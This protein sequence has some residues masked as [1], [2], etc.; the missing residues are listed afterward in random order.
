MVESASRESF[1]MLKIETFSNHTGGNALYKALSHPKTFDKM[2]QLINK[3]CQQSVALYDPLGI[4][5]PV[6]E[7]YKKS[8]EKLNITSIYAQDF[9]HIGKSYSSI[10]GIATQPLTQLHASKAEILL[11]LSFDHEPLLS[12]L[13]PYLPQFIKIYSL[14]DIR[15][16]TLNKQGRY[17]TPLNFATNF[18]FFREEDGFHTRLVTAN[19]WNRYGGKDVYLSCVLFGENGKILAQ[20]DETLRDSDHSIIIDSQE[21]K[22]RFKLEPFTGQLFFH[23]IGAVGHDVVKYA[24]N[25]FNEDGTHLSCTHDANS[26]PADSYAGLPAP[27]NNEEVYFWIQNNH[28]IPIPSTTMGLNIMGQDKISWLDKEIA[29]FATYRLNV[30]DLLPNAKWP[31]Q[32]EIHTGKYVVRPRYEVKCKSTQQQ[33]IAHVNVQRND[34]KPTIS[35]ADLKPLFGKSYILPAP[36]L[37]QATFESLALPTPMSTTQNKLPLKVFIYDATGHQVAEKSLGVLSRDLTTVIDCKQWS[38]PSGYG[39]MELAYDDDHSDVLVDGWLHGLFRYERG[40]HK[41]E[42]S[43]GA[44]IFNTALV[45]QNEPQSY[46]GAPPGLR[47]RLFLALSE[48]PQ[49]STCFLIYP[50]STPWHPTSQTTFILHNRDGQEIAEHSIKIP[51]SGSYLFSFLQSFPEEMRVKAKDGYVIVRDTTC[52]LFGYH[53]T[54]GKDAFSLDHMFGF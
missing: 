19:Y 25:T 21:I 30:A 22:T 3:I 31:Q 50:S 29:P 46:N 20:W 23:V 1:M 49:D 16:D 5:D 35:V 33:R 18:A 17:L 51:C 53:G 7:F 10:N 27:H 11:I 34:L 24:L 13:N 14:D 15:I 32:I 37:P 47:T 42:T 52:R 12:A 4:L 41:A 26:W 28:P 45:Y 40:H 39:H 2:N 43:F 6:L 44:H 38:L 9:K 54:W 8:L 36:I 48:A